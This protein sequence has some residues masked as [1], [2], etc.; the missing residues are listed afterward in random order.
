MSGSFVRRLVRKGGCILVL[1]LLC[2]TGCKSAES[3]APPLS[4]DVYDAS[5]LVVPVHPSLRFA[6]ASDLD[7]A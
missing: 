7:L 4:A 2:M 1:V 5:W 6:D 3:T